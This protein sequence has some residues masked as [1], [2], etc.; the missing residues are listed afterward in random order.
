MRS[1]FMLCTDK[2]PNQALCHC[3]DCKKISGSAYST[4]IIIPNEGFQVTSGTPKTWSKK[5]DSGSEVTTSFCGDCG[6]NMWR[7]T[8]TFGDN[9]VVKT[10]ILDNLSSLNDLKPD[11][12]LYA[13]Q[14][15]SWI[16]AVDG[17]KQ[18]K[19]MPG[20]VEC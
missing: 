1:C 2:C 7:N 3:A 15:V 6:T 20:S 4:N 11:V 18:L 13:P 9:R 17:A 8:S 12:E 10:G 19:G 5:S 16:K 14:R